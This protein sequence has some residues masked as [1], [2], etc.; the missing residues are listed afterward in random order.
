MARVNLPVG[1]SRPL[2]HRIRLRGAR[3]FIAA[4]L[5]EPSTPRVSVV[6]ALLRLAAGAILI[7][8]GF[9][10]FTHHAREVASFDRYGLPDPSVFSYAIGTL[11]VSFGMLLVIGLATRVAAPVLAGNMV[12]AIVT[13][14]RV[15]GGF[16]NL[17][18]AP[19]LLVAML[20]LLWAGGGRW[21]VDGS[22]RQR[23]AAAAS[24]P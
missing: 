10:K 3:F 21:S 1:A 19:S 16:V 15:D 18:L 12:G 5:L 11:E 17:G 13:G 7:S 14:G 9:S 24:V 20:F 22:L 2:R 8:A 4:K 6:A 23:L